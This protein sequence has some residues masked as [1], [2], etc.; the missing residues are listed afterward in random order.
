MPDSPNGSSHRTPAH[1]P[2]DTVTPYAFEVDPDQANGSSSFGGRLDG[3][4]L[5]LW[6]SFERFGGYAAGLATGLLGFA[7]VFLDPNRQAIQDRIAQTVVIRQ[8]AS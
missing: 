7:Q 3:T 2:R 4:P 8:R 5:T 1:D 6:T